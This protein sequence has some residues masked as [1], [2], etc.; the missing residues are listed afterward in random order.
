MLFTWLL[1]FIQIFFNLWLALYLY[2]LMVSHACEYID[3]YIHVFL[4]FSLLHIINWQKL[5][6]FNKCC[7]FIVILNA[8]KQWY[9]LHPNDNQFLKYLFNMH[10]KGRSVFPNTWIVSSFPKS[11]TD[12][13]IISNL[14]MCYLNY[15]VIFINYINTGIVSNFHSSI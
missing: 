5:N 10:L 12:K 4:I 13:L 9:T 7:W 3:I 6:V 2:I 8:R 11:Y 1:Y 14:K 15:Q